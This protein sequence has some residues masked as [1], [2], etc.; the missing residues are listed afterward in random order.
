MDAAQSSFKKLVL[1]LAT[2][3]L[4]SAPFRA[5]AQTLSASTSNFT[6][7]SASCN[8]FQ[9]VN[10]TSSGGANSPISFAVSVFYPNGNSSGD[11]NGAWLYASLASGGTTSTGATINGTTGTTGVAQ[12]TIGLN[13]SIG[14]VSDEAE[15]L[16][17]PTSPAGSVITI[18]AN[19]TQNANCGNTGTGNNG[20]ISYTPTTISLSSGVS[21]QESQTVAI[22]NISAAA[23][24]VVPSVSNPWLSVSTNPINLTA[25]ETYNL[26]ITANASETPGQG[27]Y[28]GT[29][30]L[31]PGTGY[32]GNVVNIPVQFTVGSGTGTGTGTGTLTV[33]GAS[34]TF[35][36][37]N[38]IAPN[39]IA[40]NCVNLVDTTS[41]VTG[42][43]WT[44]STASGGNWLYAN[45]SLGGTTPQILASGTTPTPCINLT[46]NPAVAYNLSSGAYQGT[47]NL[48][49]LEGGTA[50]ITANLYVSGGVSQGIT[51]SPGA[52]YAF[53]N[54][55]SSST[56]QQ[57]A[58]FTVTA[59]AGYNL[60]A[61]SLANSGVV[62]GLS[63]VTQNNNSLSFTVTSNST[64]LTTGLY[65]SEI[66]VPSNFSGGANTNTIITVV[67]PVG[68][69]GSTTTGTTT[70]TVAPTAL[71]FQQQSGTSWWTGGKEAQAV[72][73]SGP[74]GAT[75][76]A[77][78]TYTGGTPQWL[79]FDGASSG[80]FGS[81]PAT[82]LVDL[83][84]GV[85][86][87]AVSN[88]QYQAYVNITI[89][90]NTGPQIPVSLLVTAS[91]T[92]VLLGLPA[93]TTFSANSGANPASKTVTIV[94]SDNFNSNST[95]TPPITALTPTASWLT[96]STSGNQLTLSV[97]LGNLATGLYSAIVPIS[98]T[99]AY[100]NSINYPVVLV[101]NGGGGG[102][103]GNNGPLTLS[104]SALSY[105]NVTGSITQNLSVTATSATQFE[106]NSSETSCT[107]ANW[108][109]VV[110]GGYT[111]SSTATQIAV[112]VNP[113]SIT[114]GT[115]CNGTISLVT[116]GTN[117]ATQTVTVSMTVGTSA[118]SGNVTVSST[119]LT[120]AYTQGQSVPAAQ[121]VTIA[122]AN[123]ATAPIAFTVGT[124]ET[125]G[126]SVAWL[127]AGVTSAQTPYTLSI[128]VAPGSLPPNTYTG[129]V[130][131]TPTG[132]TAVSISVTMTITGVA[133]VTATPT[134][135]NWSYIVGGNAP[136]AT[137]IQVSAGGASAAFTATESSTGGWLQVTPIS[138]TTPN[139][140]T[141]NLSA[142][143]VAS[144]LAALLPQATP[145]TGTIT[146]QGVTQGNT[147][148]TGTTIINVS[149]TVTAPLPVITGV[150]NA[151][152]GASGSV[153]PGEIISIYGTPANPIGPATS[154]QLN[155]TTCP[156]PC[157]QVPLT[158]GG[159]TVKFL[160]GNEIAPLL[161]V[162]EG[163]INAVVP[164]TVAG[165]AALSVEVQYLGQTSNAFPVSLASTQPGIFTA[166]SSGTGPAA[167]IQYTPQ[168]VYGGTNLP[169]AP[170]SAGWTIVLFMTGEGTVSPQPTVN[171]AVTSPTGTPDPVPL[172]KP[173]VLI[174][175]QPATV[176]FYGETPGLVSGVLQINV[177]VPP[178]AGTGPVL[179]SVSMGST[180]SQQGVTVYLQ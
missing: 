160:P 94:G 27:T 21:G 75:W 35:V 32:A 158:M 29:L 110:N 144:A 98:S 4:L 37:F 46:L 133:T 107:N 128:S 179:V 55:A 132:G 99:S 49:D 59:A 163:Q 111:A 105:T 115:T 53:S 66:T 6:L 23:Y 166:N 33:N 175:G 169:N 31:T 154:V 71:T 162:N 91:N 81:G 93:L 47:V 58:T 97:S 86:S 52:I 180:A 15:V 153:S 11:S 44:V 100:S 5:S 39:T 84:N 178:G 74:Q 109:Q 155:S 19:Y 120:F 63:S 112:T 16:V 8:D 140:G 148:A 135:V 82:L 24:V 89:N 30:V 69:G 102:G 83:F 137:N 173:N 138:G 72:T 142:S 114:N 152:S 18:T 118:G 25:T 36:T 119:S 104:S 168:G 68:Q 88:T 40:G 14:G 90:G 130:T 7:G 20:F 141:F 96:A 121:T 78:I 127:Q 1:F 151:A 157:T 67:Q 54:V 101:V 3:L 87:L 50:T 143:T 92:P 60:G 176:S 131:I 124:T 174:G 41:G 164:Y 17:N 34:S 117:G 9:T 2:A 51:V 129:T 147:Q 12:L 64:G 73:I 103:G 45:N 165:I 70:T 113:A 167:A 85:G 149:L 116:T 159:V 108:L 43:S 145:Y 95:T 79:N 177:V 80:T 76:S 136:T 42:Y 65:S 22:Q 10:L 106:L 172:V 13:R 150:T 146:V 61:P 28:S 57:Q 171:G 122:N 126:T 62:F 161:F 125:N 56:V 156:T 38:Y 170:A 77:T 26:T 123:S 48:N 134:Q 139:S